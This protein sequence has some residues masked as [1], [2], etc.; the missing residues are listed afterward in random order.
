MA[1][2]GQVVAAGGGV[3]DGVRSVQLVNEAAEESIGP[4][5][6]TLLRGAFPGL[7][8]RPAPWLGALGS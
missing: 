4:W 1:Q 3:A 2:C 8:V 7:Q 6:P 5:L